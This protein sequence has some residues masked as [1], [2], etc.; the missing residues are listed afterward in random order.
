MFR[1]IVLSQWKWS[2]LVVLLATITAVALPLASLRTAV[3]GYSA[4]EF[5][6]LM[7]Q[8][9]PGYALLAAAAGLLVALSAWQQDHAGR[10]VY[11]L[12][13]PVTRTRYTAMRY[14][15]GALFLA[16]PVVAVL[17][18][19]LIVAASGAVPDGL[20]AYPLELA[21]RFALAAFVAYSIFF[22]IASSTPQTAGVVL[23]AVA[24]VLF[25]QYLLSLANTN[26]DILGPI[27]NF[28]FVDPGLFSI[29]TGRWMLVDV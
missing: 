16:S 13:L 29:F 4:V 26:V 10:H 7:Q 11:A 8:W 9:A 24:A 5:V 20:H 17:I 22:A 2:R 23:G 18:G 25:T 12:S 21:A 3:Q 15:A 27:A 28:L 19:S 6:G 14:G 1:A